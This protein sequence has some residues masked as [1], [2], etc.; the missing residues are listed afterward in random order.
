MTRLEETLMTSY[1][2]GGVGFGVGVGFGL[3][4]GTGGGGGSCLI[5]CASTVEVLI[6]A[7]AK[8]NKASAAK[9]NAGTK[10]FFAVFGNI[11]PTPHAAS[12]HHCWPNCLFD[13]FWRHDRWRD[14][15]QLI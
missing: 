2:G 15:P 12:L 8:K 14:V 10:Y 7:A 13:A 3:S 11:K 6:K 1:S 9:A 5:F 4:R